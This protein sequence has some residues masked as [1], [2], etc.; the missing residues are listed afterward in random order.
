[1]NP[2]EMI[3]YN[4]KHCFFT[5]ESNGKVMVPRFSATSI[6]DIELRGNGSLLDTLNTNAARAVLE[7]G[8]NGASVLETEKRK[9]LEFGNSGKNGKGN[10]KWKPYNP[11]FP[12]QNL[13]T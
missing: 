6:Y 11:F 3:G 13:V 4:T 10:K 12:V 5:D 1:M 2:A 8:K 9:L 7:K